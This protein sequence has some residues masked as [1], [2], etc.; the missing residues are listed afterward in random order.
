M[1]AR[2]SPSLQARKRQLT[3]IAPGDPTVDPEMAGTLRGN[4]NRIMRVQTL[5]KGLTPKAPSGM[6]AMWSGVMRMFRPKPAGRTAYPAMTAEDSLRAEGKRIN[7]A[8]FN[9]RRKP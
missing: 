4:A 5:T 2:L 1:A 3:G 7:D 8:Y 6:E 9:R